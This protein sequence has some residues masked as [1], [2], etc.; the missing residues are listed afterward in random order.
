MK[1]RL[2]FFLLIFLSGLI[3]AT[4]NFKPDLLLMSSVACGLFI[5]L[6]W[7]VGLS[8]LAG[9]FKDCFI[10]ANP[11]LLNTLLFPLWSLAAFKLNKKITI[12]SPQLYAALIAVICFLQNLIN[13]LLAVYLGLFIPAGI[14]LRII[15]T[16]VLFAALIFPLIIKL[17]KARLYG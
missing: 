3:Q 10:A 17:A 8:F 2:F 4:F 14:F 12:E 9:I 5:E 6:K 16:Q 11:Y 13:G 7:A 1:R 15:I